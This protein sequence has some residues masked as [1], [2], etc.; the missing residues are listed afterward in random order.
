GGGHLRDDRGRALIFGG[1]LRWRARRPVYA[2]VLR[3]SRD[4]RRFLQRDLLVAWVRHRR[5]DPRPVRCV[6]RRRPLGGNRYRS[7]TRQPLAAERY[8][9]SRTAATSRMSCKCGSAEPVS[10]ARAKA[11]NNPA[12][13]PGYDDLSSSAE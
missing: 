8:A 2:R 10:I 12:N 9:A 3:L 11:P 7:V 1:P 6:H 4:Q 13:H 5:L